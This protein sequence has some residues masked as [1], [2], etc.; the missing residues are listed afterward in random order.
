MGR[1][2]ETGCGRPAVDIDEQDDLGFCAAHN[3]LLLALLTDRAAREA[4]SEAVD[5]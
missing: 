2:C 5:G 1:K 4:T 3:Y